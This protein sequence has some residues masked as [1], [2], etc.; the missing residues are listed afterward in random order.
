MKRIASLFAGAALIFVG[1]SRVEAGARERPRKCTSVSGVI[2][3]TVISKAD[4]A[5]PVVLGTVTGS[6]QGAIQGVVTSLA[7]QP[8]GVLELD[9]SDHFVTH[10]GFVLETSDKA[11]LTPVGAAGVYQQNTRYT[12]SGGSGRFEHASGTFTSHGETDLNRGL[13]TSRYEGEICGVAD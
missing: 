9:I 5:Q 10:E 11:V 13:V 2:A 3:G 7:S 6:L 12:V 4:A 8:S 1:T